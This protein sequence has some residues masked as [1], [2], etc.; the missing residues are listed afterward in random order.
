MKLNFET[1]KIFVESFVDVAS[2]TFCSYGFKENVSE[3]MGL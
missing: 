2:K 1:F 3:K